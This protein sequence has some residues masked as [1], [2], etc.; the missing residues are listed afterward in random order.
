MPEKIGYSLLVLAF[1]GVLLR[2]NHLAP[3]RHAQRLAALR[4]GAPEAWFEE[5]RSLETYP[6][7]G[8]TRPWL[9]RLSN[10]AIGAWAASL[11]WSIW[12]R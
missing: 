2:Q 5:R 10:L 8:R 1:A 11:L 6:P 9:R 4:G 7:P 12:L 3:R